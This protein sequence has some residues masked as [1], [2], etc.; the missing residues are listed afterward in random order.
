MLKIERTIDKSHFR[1]H[2]VITLIKHF[3]KDNNKQ[4][5]NYYVTANYDSA[6]EN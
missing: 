6:G 2:N 1:S 4:G 3:I 5:G